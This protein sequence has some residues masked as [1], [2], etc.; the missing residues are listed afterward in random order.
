[1]TQPGQPGDI[2]P[3]PS[4]QTW[5]HSSW[6]ARVSL[7][8]HRE[9]TAYRHL[10]VWLIEVGSELRVPGDAI[11]LAIQLA[12]AESPRG[13]V[14]SVV[15]AAVLASADL[16]QLGRTGRH[17]QSWPGAPL[18]LVCPDDARW[19]E[20]GNQPEARFLQ[21]SSALL[22]AWSQLRALLP[23]RHVRLSLTPDARAARTARRFL[24]STCEE[25]AT[26]QHLSSGPIVLSE[27]VTNA[28]E[29]TGG[30]VD[31]HL[32][33]HDGELRIGVRDHADAPPV[34][35]VDDPTSTG[36]RGLRIVQSLSR[37]TGALPAS[38]GGKL[39]WA[40]LATDPVTA[41]A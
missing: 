8:A 24:S 36:G 41:P 20:L 18:L 9:I 32:A 3:V 10:D 30:P 37:A 2:G 1:M 27:L 11:D 7:G 16:E 39:V 33:E 29:H 28:V 25:W 31:V 14:C 19:A 21:R 6:A 38:G 4:D 13:V 22:H 12:L 40:V 34:T 17:V 26:P 23:G 5:A 35:R 15:D